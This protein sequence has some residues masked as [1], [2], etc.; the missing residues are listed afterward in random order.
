MVEGQILARAAI[1]ANETI[2]QENIEAGE[3][4]MPEGTHESLERDH[5]RKLHREAWTSHGLVIER[6]DVHA[7]EKHRLD[8]VLPAPHRERIVAQ[9]TKIRVEHEGGPG[10]GRHRNHQTQPLIAR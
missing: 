7:L 4:R 10:T 3:G 9:R 1:L 6:D 8:R 5:A 2:A